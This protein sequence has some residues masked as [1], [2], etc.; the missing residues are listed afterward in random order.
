MESVDFGF[1][2]LQM[3]T[4]SLPI[5]LGW[6]ARKLDFMNDAFDVQL[7]G[8]VLNFGLPCLILSSLTSVKELPATSDMLWSMAGETVMM[9]IALALGYLICALMHAPVSARPAYRFIVT[10]GNCGFIGFPVVTAVLGNG[11][12]LTAAICLIPMNFFIYT[13]GIMMFAGTGGGWRHVAQSAWNCIKSPT[14]IA[15]IVVVVCVATRFTSF[16]V[17]GKSISI[18]GQ[19]TTP[20]ALLLTGS[21]IAKYRPVEM[22]VNWRAYVAAMGR[23]LIAPIAGLAVLRLMPLSPVLMEVV[24]LVSSMPVATNG[25][26]YSLQYGA[27]TEP[28]MQGTFISILASIV[29][30]PIVVTL[31]RM[32]T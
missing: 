18:V 15:S 5:L 7:S 24:L 2:A 31:A 21:S 25:T 11:A 13:V 20:A 4:V 17:V 28:M 30:I 1:V 19:L 8:L 22:L 32:W 6:A 12:L 9:F 26:L 29:T 23:L 10:F 14:L 3:V 27:D 16:G